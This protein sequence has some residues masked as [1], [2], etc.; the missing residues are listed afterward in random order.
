MHLW[1][2]RGDFMKTAA[3]EWQGLPRLLSTREGRCK[4]WLWFNRSVIL[5]WIFLVAKAIHD[6]RA[7]WA[8]FYTFSAMC[9]LS[10]FWRRTS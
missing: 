5:V 7:G 10:A 4:A 8:S 3:Q 2:Y 1:G 6:S 9:N